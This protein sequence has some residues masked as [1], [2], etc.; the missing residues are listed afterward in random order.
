MVENY[1]HF[2]KVAKYNPR[3]QK[4]VI[5]SPFGLQ[6]RYHGVCYSGLTDPSLHDVG[7]T[8]FFSSGYEQ[9]RYEHHKHKKH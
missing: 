4:Y 9:Y 8:I 7:L 3:F 2:S 6:Y 5:R 1:G